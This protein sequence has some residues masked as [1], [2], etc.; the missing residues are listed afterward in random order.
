MKT[1]NISEYNIELNGIERVVEDMIYKA[2]LY[3]NGVLQK[4]SYIF[5]ATKNLTNCNAISSSANPNQERYL[6]ASANFCT[7]LPNTKYV[8]SAVNHMQLTYFEQ[9][10]IEQRIIPLDEFL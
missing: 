8:I 7:T 5:R 4:S 1:V 10:E 6:K 9:C 3:H 2:E